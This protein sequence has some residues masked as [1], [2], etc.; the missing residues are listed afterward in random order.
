MVSLLVAGTVTLSHGAT[1]ALRPTTAPARGAAAGRALTETERAV[2]EAGVRAVLTATVPC[3]F[4]GSD[5]RYAFT[6]QP[7][8]GHWNHGSIERWADEDEA[9]AAFEAAAGE[10]PRTCLYGYDAAE[11]EYREGT[12]P[13]MP[14]RFR[15]HVSAAGR[16]SFAFSGF[17]D[18]PYEIAARPHDL[19]EVVYEAAAR[20][21]LFPLGECPPPTTA[22]PTPSPT[23]TATEL[24]PGDIELSGLVY[25]AGEPPLPLADALVSV[26]MCVPRSFTDR[27]GADGHYRLLIPGEYANICATVTLSVTATG[28][29]PVSQTETIAALRESPKRNFVLIPARWSLHLPFAAQGTLLIAP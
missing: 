8:A 1:P 6:C 5:G 10:H 28:Y 14:M 22:E 7:A 25:G 23:P 21:G 18:T 4:T 16:W 13:G 3:T 15:E 19:A 9:A 27:T 2:L 17:D 26:T 11:W 24:P 29:E 20:E 12:E